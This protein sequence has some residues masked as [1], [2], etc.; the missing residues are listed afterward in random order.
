MNLRLCLISHTFQNKEYKHAED[1]MRSLGITYQMS[2]P[3][4]MFDSWWFW[5]CENVPDPLPCYLSVMKM[6]PAKAIGHGLSEEDVK[7]ILEFG[8]SKY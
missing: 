1:I 4:S 6:E 7:A 3:Q 8:S 5:N 2:T